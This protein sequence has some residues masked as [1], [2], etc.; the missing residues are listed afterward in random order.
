MDEDEEEEEEGGGMEDIA[1]LP[2]TQTRPAADVTMPMGN[3]VIASITTVLN[4]R[5][6]NLS[7]MLHIIFTIVTCKILTNSIFAIAEIAAR[8]LGKPIVSTPM[9]HSFSLEDAAATCGADGHSVHEQEARPLPAL[10]PICRWS[11]SLSLWCPWCSRLCDARHVYVM[12]PF[13]SHAMRAC[14]CIWYFAC[15]RVYVCLCVHVCVHA[16]I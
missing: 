11:L 9:P 13:H 4:H 15:A 6:V 12:A 10:L 8:A 2:S 5:I 3:S 16:H 14:A 7:L 1:T